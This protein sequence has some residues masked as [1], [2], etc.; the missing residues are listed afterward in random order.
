M[1]QRLSNVTIEK[2]IVYGNSAFLLKEKHNDSS[3]KWTVYVRGLNNEDMSYFIKSVTFKLHDSFKDPVRVIHTPPY[4]VTEYGWGEFAIQI[5]IAFKDQADEVP[6]VITHNLKLFLDPK[7]IKEKKEANHKKPVMSEAYDELV[8][9][10]PTQQFYAMLNMEPQQLP[11]N[12]LKPH[13]TN[14]TILDQEAK[15]LNRIRSAQDSVN[16]HI[17]RLRAKLYEVDTEIAALETVGNQ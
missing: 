6:V 12:V 10:E 1:S 14:Q 16:A 11:P 8:F 5:I 15:Q 13:Y 2:P 17:M 3:H 4:E 7:D 9:V